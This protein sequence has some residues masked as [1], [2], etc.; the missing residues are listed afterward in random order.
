MHR[1]GYL[2]PVVMLAAAFTARAAQA[3]TAPAP[4][5]PTLDV[6]TLR[7]MRDKGILTQAEYD[8]ALTD[9]VDSSGARA[10]DTSS[11]VFARWSATLYGFFESDYIFDS[12]QSYT[13]LA[14]GAL[15][16]HPG[17]YAADHPRMQFSL[18]NTR[19]GLRLRAP[20]YREIRASARVETDLV[21]DWASPSYSGAS[22]QPSENQFF[23]SPGLRIRH[24]YVKV[25]TLV[26]D[27]LA[28]Q[29]LTPVRLAARLP[30]EH[31]G[32]AGRLLADRAGAALRDL[33]RQERPTRRRHRGHAT[34]P[35]RLRHPRGRSCHPLRRHR[36]TG[37]Q[38]LGATGATISPASLTI[39]GDVRGFS[40]ANYPTGGT[41]AAPSLKSTSGVSEMGGAVA[42]DAF[43]PLVR[44]TKND[45]G[46][47]LSFM[48]ELVYGQGMGDLYAGLTSG[49]GV[50]ALVPVP[51][52]SPAGIVSTTPY[53]PQIDPGFVSVDGVG[54]VSVI[55]WQTIRLGLQYTLPRLDGKMWIAANYANVSAPNAPS[56]VTPRAG[57]LLDALRPIPYAFRNLF[58]LYFM[59]ELRPRFTSASSTTTPT[60][61]TVTAST[62]STTACSARPTT[63]S[64]GSCS[65]MSRMTYRRLEL[66]PGG[67]RHGHLYL[68]PVMILLAASTAAPRPRRPRPTR[69]RRS[70]S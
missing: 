25:E 62:A 46:D 55:E 30:A 39:S 34:A 41:V 13:D 19:I 70:R 29:T 61:S 9:L 56:L 4:S 18:R 28:G 43:I 11:L 37:I 8:S 65:A 58:N 64:E 48:G 24:A 42:L 1:T 3:Q 57:I 12:T 38:T 5:S 60:T 20:E 66:A 2:L 16:A 33:H 45:M 21:G 36:R 50:P 22:G 51:A 15:I 54:N 31:A 40:V 47:A 10:G 59:S 14:G 44:A 52:G 63:S 67:R 68:A 26:V 53:N 27:V 35:A 32:G 69:P 6:M 7:I 17:T 23:T 49:L